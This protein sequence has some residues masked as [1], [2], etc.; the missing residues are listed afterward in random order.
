MRWPATARRRWRPGVTN[1]TPSRGRFRA[2]SARSRPCSAG[3]P[4]PGGNPMADRPGDTMGFATAR[5]TFYVLGSVALVV[6]ALYW[7]QRIFVPLALAVLLTL[8][9]SPVVARLERLG[10]RRLSA[11]LSAAGLAFLL[12]GLAVWAVAAQ[13]TSLLDDLPKHRAN[14]RAKFA[15]LRGS[16]KKGPLGALQE[17]VEEIETGGSPPPGAG[18][19]VRVEPVKPSLLAQLRPVV[20]RAVGAVSLGAVAALLVVTL[21]LNRE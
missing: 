4:R 14:V 8:L 15:Q 3:Q 21:L 19:V 13:V 5:R 16:G 9:L 1:T 7:G 20:G 17:F 10:L 2:C 18:P 6:S 12:I 11:V